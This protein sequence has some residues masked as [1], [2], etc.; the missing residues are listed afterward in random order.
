VAPPP[1]SPPPTATHRRGAAS[2]GRHPSN[3][4][5]ES[6]PSAALPYFPQLPA[7]AEAQ[8]RRP[9]A[10]DALDGLL[11]FPAGREEEERAYLPMTPSP[12]FYLLKNPPTYCFYSKRNPG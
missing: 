1:S 4:G 5:G 12:I 2:A 10:A 7:A 8:G 9:S 11:C 3:R 6:V